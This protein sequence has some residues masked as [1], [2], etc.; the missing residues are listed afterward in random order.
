[1]LG[2]KVKPLLIGWKYFGG[3][4]SKN[5]FPRTVDAF[6]EVGPVLIRK[7]YDIYKYDFELFGYKPD[8]YFNII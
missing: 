6:R 1:M 8:K 3:K 2:G 4:V 7:L 5:L